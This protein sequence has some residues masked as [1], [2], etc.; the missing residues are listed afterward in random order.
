MAA[1]A[2]ALLDELMGRTRNLDPSQ[3][4]ED[5]SWNSPDKPVE[6]LES[7]HVMNLEQDMVNF[8]FSLVVQKLCNIIPPSKFGPVS[9]GT[10]DPTR[11]RYK[12]FLECTL[13]LTSVVPPELPIELSLA[14]NTSLLALTKL[15]VYC[16]EPFRIPFAGKIDICCF[17]KTG[18]LTSDNLVVEGITGLNGT[19]VIAANE[20]PLETLQVLA[21]CHS[22]VQLDEELVGDPLE[23]A[24]LKAVEWTL[25]KGET[26]VPQKKKTHGLKIYHR[27]HFQSVLKRM[28]VVIG[29]TP[30]GST[31]IQYSAAVKGA[32]ETL[33]PMFSNLPSNYDEVYLKMA[34]RGARVL[35]LGYKK[36]G[37]MSHQQVRDLSRDVV[38]KDLE[39][40]GF[41]IISCPLKSDSKAAIKEIL[42]SS[43]Y[44]VMI[45]GDNPLTACHVAKELKMTRKETTVVLQPPNDFA[46]EWHW[47]SIDDKIVIKAKPV[48]PKKDLLTLYDLCLTGEALTYLQAGDKKYFHLLLASAKVFARV[49]PKQKELIIT[50]LKSLGFVTLMCGDGTND[51]GAL[52]HADV[53]KELENQLCLREQELEQC[54]CC[55]EELNA[56]IRALNSC[57]S[58]SHVRVMSESESCQRQS[59]S[60]GHVRVMSESCQSQ[61]HVRVMSESCQSQS[62]VRVRTA[63]NDVNG[64]GE[65]KNTMDFAQ[66]LKQCKE[67]VKKLEQEVDELKK[68]L[69]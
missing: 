17:D 27:F 33:K 6:L 65:E 61:S 36:F 5:L 15:Y 59:Q 10:E 34:R 16:T 63:T 38:E 69:E 21:T 44:V 49:A 35:A 67:R 20:A 42:H 39:F 14:V 23:K 31:E 56:K 8:I 4:P 3:Q 13:I 53:V 60:Q 58:Q 43:H 22:L 48:N 68:K 26:V 7:N 47:Q 32:P 12:L 40:A 41:V 45:T 30:A 18:T 52:K 46:D 2:K 11:N 25:T 37:N 29:H 66:Q 28:S 9:K 19:D 55:I 50:T 64:D 51:V 57:Q 24:T 54:Q 62:H 1:E